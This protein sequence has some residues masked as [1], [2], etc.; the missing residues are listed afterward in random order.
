MVHL[1][2]LVTELL[3]CP[4]VGGT[5]AMD[6]WALI[7]IGGTY[8]YNRQK[9]VEKYL[10]YAY[11][12]VDAARTPKFHK[13]R[14]NYLPGPNIVANWPVFADRG[15]INNSGRYYVAAGDGNAASGNH[16]ATPGMQ[17]VLGGAHGAIVAHTETFDHPDRPARYSYDETDQCMVGFSDGVVFDNIYQNSDQYPNGDYNKDGHCNDTYLLSSQYNDPNY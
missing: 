12:D 7:G 16:P 1:D 15:A 17:N 13:G 3:L 4:T 10:H 6:E 2:Y 11:Q 8:D 9:A 14:G 5:K